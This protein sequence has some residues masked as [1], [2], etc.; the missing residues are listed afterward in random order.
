[1]ELAVGGGGVG[2][3]RTLPAVEVSRSNTDEDTQP[4]KVSNFFSFVQVVQNMG[5][6][7]T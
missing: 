3:R 6:D 7:I 5:N 2:G 1:M 4:A